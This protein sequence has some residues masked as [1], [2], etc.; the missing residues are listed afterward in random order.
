MHTQKNSKSLLKNNYNYNN[1]LYQHR[2]RIKSNDF[3][4]SFSQKNSEFYLSTTQGVDNDIVGKFLGE[5]NKDINE[6]LYIKNNEINKMIERGPKTKREKS[7]NETSFNE[8]MKRNDS[9]NNKYSSL[10]NSSQ[11]GSLKNIK[12]NIHFFGIRTN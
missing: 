6:S 5:T 10:R 8:I 12:N 3:N 2:N 4:E 11:K 9:M 1:N 7:L